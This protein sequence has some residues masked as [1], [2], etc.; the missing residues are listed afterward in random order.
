MANPQP[1]IDE[2]LAIMH[3]DELQFW[4][5]GSGSPK[6]RDEFLEGIKVRWRERQRSVIAS[7]TPE[8]PESKPDDNTPIYSDTGILDVPEATTPVVSE[9]P[10]ESYHVHI[11]KGVGAFLLS[12]G[13]TAV[14]GLIIGAL[15]I[16]G[17]ISM[18]VAHLLIGL[19]W[20]IAVF[21]VWLWLLSRP[22]KH[23]M[24][25]VLLTAFAFGVALFSID[26]WM[27]WQKAEQERAARQPSPEVHATP[28]VQL[29][30]HPTSKPL[31]LVI[32]ALMM[33]GK[34]ASET[35]ATTEQVDLLVTKIGEAYDAFLKESNRFGSADEID[36]G[37]RTALYF[38][39]AAD[40]LTRRQN[41]PVSV[42]NRLQ[43]TAS[44]LNLVKTLMSQ[45]PSQSQDSSQQG[46]VCDD[47]EKIVDNEQVQLCQ[48]RK[49]DTDT[50][51]ID[52]VEENIAAANRAKAKLGCK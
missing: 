31:A 41:Y 34:L 11:S 28:I 36:R 1:T 10:K 38:T 16:A 18:G 46:T 47:L 6:Q 33:A 45:T 21:A 4:K 13:F 42:Q 27:V 8:S 43:I 26:R 52:G 24:K 32:D 9:Q 44:R 17:V 3:A 15:Q 5:S 39:R 25:I 35:N 14:V 20:V 51:S 2:L 50:A 22:R 48:L 30:P 23:I 40:A 19:A 37:L 49:I 7:S 29:Q 12:V